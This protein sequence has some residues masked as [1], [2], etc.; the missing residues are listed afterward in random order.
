MKV[1]LLYT[2]QKAHKEK[3]RSL[4]VSRLYVFSPKL[5]FTTQLI[6]SSKYKLKL[7][8]CPVSEDREKIKSRISLCIKA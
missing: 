7:N 3:T 2:K 5:T 8:L 6:Y 1:V 4:F